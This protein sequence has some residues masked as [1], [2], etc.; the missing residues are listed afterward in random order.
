MKKVA[1]I[2]V[3][4][5]A[6]VALTGC[7]RQII[8]LTYKFDIAYISLP[9]GEVV[10][11]KVDSWTDFEQDGDMLQVKID[12]KTYLTHSANVILVAE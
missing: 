11:G 6:M 4:V 12:G 3:L 5:L 8:D 10:E 9:N 7:N 1:V 2:L